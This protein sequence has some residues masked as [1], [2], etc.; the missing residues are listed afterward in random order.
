MSN[1]YPDLAR[2]VIESGCKFLRQGEYENGSH[3]Q[4]NPEICGVAK[5]F[6]GRSA[7]EGNAPAGWLELA[8]A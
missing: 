3:G 5:G 1:L 8:D 6:A 2:L 7:A 4:R